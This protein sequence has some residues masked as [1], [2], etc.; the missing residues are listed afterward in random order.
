MRYLPMLV[1]I[2]FVFVLAFTV[3]AAAAAEPFAPRPVD[4][5][6]AQ[7]LSRAMRQSATVRDLVAMLESSNV[8][9]HIET[10]WNMPAGIAGLT[11]FVTSRGGYR[12]VRITLSSGLA[13]KARTAILGHELQHACE[14]AASSAD[15]ADSIRQL[16]ES[17]G[18]RQGRYFETRAA[19]AAEK[20]ARRELRTA[21]AAVRSLQTE[22]V[23][24]F[25][26]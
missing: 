7:A 18:H 22:P 25:D 10:S 20:S 24:K 4:P 6:A 2:V 1:V 11:R 13:G 19:L 12:Y 14:V 5:P 21:A 15:D 23:T 17:E 8:I 3:A 9:V 16:F 26:H